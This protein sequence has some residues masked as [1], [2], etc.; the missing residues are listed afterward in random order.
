MDLVLLPEVLPSQPGIWDSRT[1]NPLQVPP[2]AYPAAMN[3]DDA[4]LRGR[5]DR[6]SQG[7]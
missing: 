2:G 6:P 1:T 4:G 5:V 7:W 3:L